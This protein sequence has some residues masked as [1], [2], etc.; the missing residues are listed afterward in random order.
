MDEQSQPLKLNGALA[1]RSRRP[2]PEGPAGSIDKRK[3]QNRE[4]QRTY[5]KYP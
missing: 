1:R 5:R 3:L 4:S 2:R